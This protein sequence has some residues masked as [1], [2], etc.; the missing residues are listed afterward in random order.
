M[1][2]KNGECSWRIKCELLTG[3]RMPWFN[4]KWP[5]LLFWPLSLLYGAILSIRNFC[6]DV[7]IFKSYAVKS[8]VISVGNI[9]VGGTGKTPTV[10]YLANYFTSL[11]YKVAVTSRGYGRSSKGT[12]VVSD[13]RSIQ[14]SVD[15]AGDEPYLISQSCPNA[16][17][18]VDAD[19]VR[20]AQYAEST[21]APDIILMDDAFQHRRLKRDFDLLTMRQLRP[22]DNEFCLP[23]GP[24]REPKRYLARADALLLNGAQQS[25]FEQFGPRIAEVFVAQYVPTLLINK[26]GK[27]AP[28]DFKGK[29]VFAF[30]GLAN[31]ESFRTTLRNLGVNFSGFVAYKDHYRYGTDDIAKIKALAGES[32]VV[33]T[34]EKDWVK[35]P[36]DQIDEHWYRL[37]IVI[38]P[39]DE[40]KLVSLFEILK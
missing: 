15:K 23:A 39:T 18:I 37:H 17:V 27:T 36:L 29:S 24:L 21:F 19:R 38:K 12:I 6:Y 1:S 33:V 13:G 22:L 4:F 25:V 32:D 3:K 26:D 30:C 34:T 9:S 8:Y 11:N 14:V 10:I 31:P 35:L 2:W 28:L 5:A 20:A 16:I 7:G 40:Q